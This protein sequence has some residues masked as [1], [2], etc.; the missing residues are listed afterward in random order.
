MVFVAR[1]VEDDLL[2]ACGLGALSDKLADLCTLGLLVA[3]EGADLRLHGGGGDQGVTG[4]VVDDL[5]VQVAGAAVHDQT[6]R[7]GGATQ[8][9]ADTEV[10][11]CASLATA[12]GDV[13]ADRGALGVL[14]AHCLLTRLSDLATDLL[15]LVADALTLVGVVLPQ[16]TDVGGDLSDLLLVNTRDGELGG[17]VNREGDA[18]RSLD[19]ERVGV[20]QGKLEVL[21]L[22]LD[23]VTDAI[24]M[25]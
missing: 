12:G 6:R 7:L 4:Q 15:T 22:G 3:L 1:T 20:A 11:T 14:S 25:V 18:L 24:L 13:L 21:A 5:D 19:Q 9:L 23:T 17:A 8:G 16:T 10:T 2:D